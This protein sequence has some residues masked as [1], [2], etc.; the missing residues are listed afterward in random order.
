MKTTIA[1]LLALA[2]PAGAAEDLFSADQFKQAQVVL[3]V[4]KTMIGNG[5]CDKYCWPEARVLK[6]LKN[7]S[8][9]KFKVDDLIHIAVLGTGGRMPQGEFTV[10][11]ERYNKAEKKPNKDWIWKALGGSVEAGTSHL[12]ALPP[13]TDCK[14][15]THPHTGMT[16][17]PGCCPDGAVCD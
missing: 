15:G 5:A 14:K 11:L 10:Y 4:S 8:K 12:T 2:A 16:G 3:R 17:I 6:V 7:S 1:L 13:R 9:Q